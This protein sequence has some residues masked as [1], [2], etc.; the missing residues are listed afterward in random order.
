[1]IGA[2]EKCDLFKTIQNSNVIP[3]KTKHKLKENDV[4]I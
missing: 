4:T 1:M 3:W 2:F